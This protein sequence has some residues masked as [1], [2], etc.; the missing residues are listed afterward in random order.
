M[1]KKYHLQVA[2]DEEFSNIIF[3]KKEL[4][5][6]AYSISQAGLDVA[7]KYYWRMRLIADGI[8]GLWSVV[9]NF[10]TGLHSPT[11]IYPANDATK[12][13]VNCEFSWQSVSQ[14][15]FYYLQ[16]AIDK[17]FTNLVHDI[18]NI[19]ETKKSVT[20]DSGMVYYWHVKAK[21]SA[22]EGS[23]SYTRSLQ[24][25]GNPSSIDNLDG[26]LEYLSVIPNPVNDKTEIKLILNSY[27]KVRID[28]IDSY[29]RTVKG[30]LDSYQPAGE[31][32]VSWRPENL[33][34]GVYF[35]TGT[36]RK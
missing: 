21:Y 11:L 7:T 2:T 35:F 27:G 22:G 32:V 16:I 15:E 29:G 17:N 33:P 1:Q 4:T 8:A 3:E 12:I 18:D 14:A 36:R 25:A 34:C 6:K 31:L 9:Y 10:K 26:P 5:G 30:L 19:T 24:T 20:L 28:L 13:D 23:W